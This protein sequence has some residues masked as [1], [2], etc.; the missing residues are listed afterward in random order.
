MEAPMSTRD[1]Q[2]EMNSGID[3][4]GILRTLLVQIIVL[5]ALTGAVVGYLNWSSDVNVTEFM[6]A[7]QSLAHDPRQHPLFSVP[8]QTVRGQGHCDRKS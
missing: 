5:V 1:L 4:P 8:V 7:S 3:W 6:A 2:S